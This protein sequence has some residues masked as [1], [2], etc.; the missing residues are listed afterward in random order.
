NIITG[1]GAGAK[2]EVRVFNE[3][4]QLVSSIMAYDPSFRG[5]VNVGTGRI[6]GRAFPSIVTGAGQGAT[7][8]VAVFAVDYRNPD[9][10]PPPEPKWYTVAR[11]LA[12]EANFRGGVSVSSVQ[13]PFAD[14]LLTG[15][16]RGGPPEVKRFRFEGD[17]LAEIA[18]FL[19]FDEKR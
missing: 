13:T 2:P 15:R 11:R 7:P 12:F 6:N 16:G 3:V 17:A 9:E 19:A 4:F 1:P 10:A 14:D 5:G 18:S 8:E